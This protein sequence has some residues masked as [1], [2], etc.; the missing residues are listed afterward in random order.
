MA[1]PLCRQSEISC[2]KI[3]FF[4]I[5]LLLSGCAS[6]VDVTYNCDP[7]GAKL[8]EAHTGKIFDCPTTLAYS[9]SS[10]DFGRGYAVVDGLIAI[11]VSGAKTR[12]KKIRINLT[13]G[14]NQEFTFQRNP[15]AP[16]AYLDAKYA[17][18][19]QTVQNQKNLVAT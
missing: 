4:V 9:V 5:I 18:Q 3:P 6:Q 8:V 17:L 12:V 1:S 10:Q 13:P 2:E 7:V 19:I 15:L 11:W 16:N 14:T